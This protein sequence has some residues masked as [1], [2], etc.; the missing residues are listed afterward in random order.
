MQKTDILL[1]MRVK[2]SEHRLGNVTDLRPDRQF[3]VEI[4]FD[5]GLRQAILIDKIRKVSQSG[6]Q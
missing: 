1:G 6:G 2:N 5:S 4:T 3:L